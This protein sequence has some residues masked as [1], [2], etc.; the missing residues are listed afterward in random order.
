MLRETSR[1]ANE[2]KRAKH[3]TNTHSLNQTRAPTFETQKGND[4]RRLWAVRKALPQRLKKVGEKNKTVENILEE[5]QWKK[6]T[7]ARVRHLF[8][9]T[10]ME[11]WDYTCAKKQDHAVGSPRRAIIFRKRWKTSEHIAHT[12]VHIFRTNN[13]IKQIKISNQSRSQCTMN[14]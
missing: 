8:T 14:C 9:Q 7:H 3:N 1:C 12:V 13:K 5:K 10:K 11:N 6:K 4:M 2:R